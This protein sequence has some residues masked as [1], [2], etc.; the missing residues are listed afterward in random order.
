MWSPRWTTIVSRRFRVSFS[1]FSSFSKP[2]TT[3]TT[4]AHSL[5][6]LLLVLG[7]GKKRRG[8]S[9]QHTGPRFVTAGGN[10]ACLSSC[11][12]PLEMKRRFK[13]TGDTLFTRHI[14]PTTSISNPLCGCRQVWVYKHQRYWTKLFKMF[15]CFHW[16]NV[17]SLQELQT[18]PGHDVFLC[19]VIGLS[20]D[21]VLA[22]TDRV[23][24]TTDWTLPLSVARS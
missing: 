13:K 12:V 4:F 16:T 3:C 7:L 11:V 18:I 23:E 22:Q 19:A 17:V 21:L 20:V 24:Y 14:V 10:V 2:S 9:F 15:G 5:V 1:S 6:V 8:L